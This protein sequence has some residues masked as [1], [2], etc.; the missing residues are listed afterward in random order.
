NRYFTEKILPPLKT[1]PGKKEIIIDKPYLYGRDLLIKKIVVKQKARLDI[2]S[3]FY[4]QILYTIEKVS[5][6]VNGHI[7]VRRVIPNNAEI[8]GLISRDL[9][10]DINRLDQT[11]GQ[12]ATA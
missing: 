12:P 6:S 11:Y 1:D 4:A 10:A 3:G 2:K 8:A 5:F 9:R 7:I